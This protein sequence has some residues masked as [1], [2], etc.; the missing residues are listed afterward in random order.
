MSDVQSFPP[1]PEAPAR[2]KTKRLKV[3][4]LVLVPL[5]V[6]GGL[7]WWINRPIRPVVLTPPELELV[8][9]KVGAI[10]AGERREEIRVDVGGPVYEKGRKEIVLTERELNGLLNENTTLGESLRFE[11]ADGA[12]H[13]RVEMDLDPDLPVAGGKRLKARARFLVGAGD[14]PPELVLDD[15]TVWGVSLPN[16]WLGG[17]KG[18]NL[19]G[20][21]FG[22]GGRGIPGVEELVIERGRLR[23][24]LKE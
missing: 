11:L 23:V 12:V 24:K 1:P 7:F 2:R 6:L 5:L 16:D 4:V 17:I 20:E 10:Q 19:F 9:A 15:V 21:V 8:E 18:M 22:T 3:L 13:A 14:G